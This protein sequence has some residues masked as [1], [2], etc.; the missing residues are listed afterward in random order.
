M[1]NTYQYIEENISLV[2]NDAENS[3]GG[4][5]VELADG[6]MLVP[7]TNDILSFDNAL[8]KFGSLISKA[9]YVKITIFSGKSNNPARVYFLTNEPTE[10]LGN[11]PTN[12]ITTKN[13]FTQQDF[14]KA[15][16]EERDKWEKQSA[17]QNLTSESIRKDEVI[18]SKDKEIGLLEEKVKVL[19]ANNLGK[20]LKGFAENPQQSLGLM[21]MVGTGMDMFKNFQNGNNISQVALNGL[22]QYEEETPIFNIVRNIFKQID[23]EQKQVFMEVLQLIANN[24]QENI[25]SLH[26]WTQPEQEWEQQKPQEPQEVA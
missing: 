16:E 7:R 1:Q 15:L 19:E 4:Y 24:P 10:S 25:A 3:A 14:K 22:N 11:V 12:S 5:K 17:M 18:R 8:E 23:T 2:R 13:T 6:A 20:I 26:A 9:K 21:T